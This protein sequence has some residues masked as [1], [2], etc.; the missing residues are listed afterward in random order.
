M[1]S[2]ALW[3]FCP[4]L[5]LA[6]CCA[7]GAVAAEAQQPF[8]PRG[9]DQ[10]WLVNTRGVGC[11]DRLGWGIARY[12]AGYWVGSDDSAFAASDDEE[13]ATVIYIH[14][15]RMDA[16]GAEARGLAIYREL[17]SSHAGGKVRFVI[18]SWPA[19]Q[20]HGPFRDVRAK[21]ARSDEEA[22]LLARFLA[23][24]PAKRR[25]GLIGFS[26]GARI[27]GGAL[28]ILG[29]GEVNGRT[30]QSGERASF[31]VVFWAAGVQNDWLLP[32]NVQRRALP[33]GQAWLNVY[34]SCD[35]ILARFDRVDRCDC[36]PGL[37]HTGLAGKNQLPA[38]LASR[39]ED[40]DA[41]RLVGDDHRSEPYFFQSEIIRRTR[42][43]LL[44]K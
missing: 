22:Y 34:N 32:D 11:V 36:S 39:Y 28:H 29:D 42:E 30:V 44:A 7:A 21:A 14:G 18:W 37:G 6:L 40:W 12:E 35:R 25:A 24:I 23:P 27:I 4:T 10:I 9:G 33:L 2:A 31:R 8:Q 19:D 15:N 17:F 38:E 43:T 41:A 20:I 5:L 16:A 26:Y 13:T 1:T 3:R